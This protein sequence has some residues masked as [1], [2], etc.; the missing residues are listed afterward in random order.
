MTEK[1]Q[2][3]E[4]RKFK[5]TMVATSC[6][7]LKHRKEI[8]KAL[9]KLK[10]HIPGEYII[11]PGFCIFR[12]I[13]SFKEGFDVEAG[14]P[15]SKVFK[16]D[17]IKTRVIPKMEV[18]SLIHRGPREKLGESY[19]KLYGYA[20]QHGLISDEFCREIYLDFD[21]VEGGVTEIQFIIH[22]WEELLAENLRKALGEKEEQK[23]MQAI[24]DL[25]VHSTV[26]ERFN[27]V[28]RFL[29]K[30]Q[31]I[32]GEEEMY[33]IL[34]GCA[35]IFPRSQIGKIKQVYDEE[36]SKTGDAMEAIDAVI[37]FMGKDP[38]W[39]KRPLRKGK[40]I[41]SSKNPRDPE[42]YKNAKTE[43]EKKK[44]YCFCPLIRE[45][46]DGGMPYAFCYCG[47]GWYKQQWEE[48]IGKPVTIE[49][50]KSILKGD[51]SCKFAIRLPEDL[52]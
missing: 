27:Q 30:L 14:F 21:A 28:K 38:G 48:T 8:K 47:A 31:D 22:K 26:E 52:C 7:N 13:T 2:K 41:Y 44:V 5:D 49:I 24:N 20:Y 51:N 12:F 6:F 11:G 23:L 16:N 1:K 19:K 39:G 35:H 18:L 15:V 34:S 37:D 3:I 50:E 9:D 32:A 33:K 45:H 46:L 10:E 42:G 36:V 17:T 29:E 4:Y 43:L 40:V 25:S